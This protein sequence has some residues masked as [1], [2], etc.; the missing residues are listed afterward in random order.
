MDIASVLCR[1]QGIQDRYSPLLA[2]TLQYRL[3]LQG[4]KH[5]V[6]K[7]LRWPLQVWSC[8]VGWEQRKGC[9]ERDGSELGS[10][11]N[12]WIFMKVAQNTISHIKKSPALVIIRGWARRAESKRWNLCSSLPGKMGNKPTSTFPNRTCALWLYSCRKL[13]SE[14]WRGKV[15]GAAKSGIQTCLV[16]SLDQ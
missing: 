8:R 3:W 13:C 1:C 2:H 6:R 9:G 5:V 14:G 12:M 11:I 15:E 10:D 16:T 4:C 7:R